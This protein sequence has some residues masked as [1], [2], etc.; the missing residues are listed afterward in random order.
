MKVA[1][2]VPGGV[3]RS[4]TERVIPCLLWLIERLVAAGLELHVFAAAQEDRPGAWPLLGA[5]VHNAGAHPR[6]ARMLAALAA[7]HRRAPFDVLHAVW[8]APAGVVA[9]AA[10]ALLRV[11][12]LLHLTGGDLT[13]LPDIGYGVR[14]RRRGRAWLRLAL[15]GADRIT[16]PSAYVLEQA[17]ALGIAAERLTYGVALDRWPP[18][19]PRRREPGAPARLLHVGSLNPVKDQGTLL[20]AAARLRDAGV[21]FRLDIVGEDTLGGKVQRE[22]AALRL[23]DDVVAFHG[24]LPH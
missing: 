7:E 11:P 6:R 20:R 12:V 14:V 3:D 2:L 15:A 9:A 23:G 5:R 16:V 17:R 13:A 10:G 1:L 4:G 24:F 18:L 21:A 22:A 8:A 19:A